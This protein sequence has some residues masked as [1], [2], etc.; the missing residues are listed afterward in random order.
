M[1]HLKTIQP[2]KSAG[3]SVYEFLRNSIIQLWFKPGQRLNIREL[4]E[5]LKVSRSPIRDALIRLGKEGLIVSEPQ[6]STLVSKIDVDRAS[7]EF[8][9]RLCVEEKVLEQF[10][11]IATKEHIR[12]LEEN[13]A[14]QKKSRDNNDYRTFLNQDDQFHQYF[15]EQSDKGV[16][17]QLLHD[18]IGHYNRV[19]LLSCMEEPM[20]DDTI[21]QHEELIGFIRNKEKREARRSVYSHLMKINMDVPKL[22]EKYPKLFVG[23]AAKQEHASSIFRTD[24]LDTL[25]SL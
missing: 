19:R 21:K 15:Y 13:I 20:L 23:T 1:P 2:Q 22:T 17:F 16:C 14:A 25:M 24:Y 7:N 9:L 8:F 4:T 11:D 6:R 5:Y 12:F 3:E 18:N 10:V